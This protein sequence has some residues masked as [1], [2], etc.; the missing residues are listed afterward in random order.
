MTNLAQKQR[1]FADLAFL[2]AFLLNL[3][4]KKEQSMRQI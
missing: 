2:S 3:V 1:L 4:L